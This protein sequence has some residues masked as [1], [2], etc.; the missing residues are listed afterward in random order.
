M[1]R[2]LILNANEGQLKLILAKT[3]QAYSKKWKHSQTQQ[4]LNHY[5]STAF[6][7]RLLA[8]TMTTLRS[9]ESKGRKGT[10]SRFAILSYLTR[11]YRPL[12]SLS[13]SLLWRL[14]PPSLWLFGA[15]NDKNCVVMGSDLW[16]ENKRESKFFTPLI[17]YF[18]FE[19]IKICF[20]KNIILNLITNT[21][22]NLNIYFYSN[23]NT[24]FVII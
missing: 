9:N 19:V 14:S 8:T 23:L 11:S 5:C 1:C 18:N 13:N 10:R 3:E 15:C 21:I 4:Q 22:R 20:K 17:C 24:I 12:S 2:T 16:L 7:L 6:G